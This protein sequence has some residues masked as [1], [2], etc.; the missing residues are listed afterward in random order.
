MVQRRDV[1]VQMLVAP[2]SSDRHP[3]SRQA[4]TV[5]VD[6]PSHGVTGRALSQNEVSESRDTLL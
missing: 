6:R 2:M 5:Y 4:R 3:V 1:Y